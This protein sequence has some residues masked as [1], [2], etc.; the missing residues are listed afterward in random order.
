VPPPKM[1][2]DPE[3]LAKLQ[4]SVRTLPWRATPRA[5]VAASH[6]RARA[7]H[8]RQERASTPAT[9]RPARGRARRGPAALESIP[10][11]A[12]PCCA[13]PRR[14]GSWLRA[15]QVRTGGKGTVRRKKKAVHKTASTDDK[16]LQVCATRINPAYTLCAPALS[17]GA[18]LF[19]PARSEFPAL[20]TPPRGISSTINC[21]HVEKPCA[22][23]GEFL[24][25]QFWQETN[26][27][28]GQAPL[29]MVFLCASVLGQ[30]VVPGGGLGLCKLGK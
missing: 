9:L 15:L 19:V 10:D 18:Q 4:A 13:A 14:P 3:K 29:S 30:D 2:V 21:P 1:P 11:R 23:V 26:L 28:G 20:P 7:V 24:P 16:R 17:P 5:L 27:F 8:S 22:Q 12:R 25:P 6:C